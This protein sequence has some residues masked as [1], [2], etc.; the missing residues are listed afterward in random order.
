MQR[1]VRLNTLRILSTPQRYYS[2]TSD[3]QETTIAN[4]ND[5]DKMGMYQ[6]QVDNM[7]RF[8]TETNKVKSDVEGDIKKTDDTKSA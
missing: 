2:K 3:A 1:I 6:N 7:T 8:Q 4:A 5:K